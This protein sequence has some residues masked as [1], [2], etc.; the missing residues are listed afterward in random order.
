ML[1]EFPNFLASAPPP[2]V[3]C[4]DVC[5]LPRPRRLNKFNVG[6][7]TDT[8]IR[9]VCSPGKCAPRPIITQYRLLQQCEWRRPAAMTVA[10]NIPI[11]TKAVP[12]TVLQMMMMM[13]M[14]MTMMMM[15]IMMA[16]AMMLVVSVGS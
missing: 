6:A 12:E 9:V 7:D 16:M 4:K 15:M 13:M 11:L 3:I 1:L 5:G 14:M 8:L 10:V 2:L